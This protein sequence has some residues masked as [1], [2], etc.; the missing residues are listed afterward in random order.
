MPGTLHIVA[1]PIG[2]LEDLSPRA[3]RVLAESAVIAC[4]DT[5]HSARLLAHFGL[6][7]PTI[8]CH[9][10]NESARSHELL[11]RLQRGENIALISDAGMPTIS[12]PGRRLIAAALGAGVSVVPVPGPSAPLAALA[13]SGW[14]GPFYFAGFLPARA[15]ERRRMLD[16]WR[17]RE[18]IIVF[19]EAPHRVAAALAD[20]V[21]VFGPQREVVVAREL[22]KLHEEVFR[23]SLAAAAVH[24]SSSPPK[25]EFTFVLAARSPDRIPAPPPPD[26]LAL[27][28]ARL[29]GMVAA[30]EDERVAL[31]RVAREFSLPKARLYRARLEANSKNLRQ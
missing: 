18:E 30:G 11:A 16:S 1:T 15:G 26:A 25:G 29:A 4:E 12:D 9:E 19:F 5:R 20:L 31:K 21:A 8:S 24:F 2:N 23:G 27:A 13:A 14:D 3:R 7:T 10:H 28:L 17:A 6:A 22:T